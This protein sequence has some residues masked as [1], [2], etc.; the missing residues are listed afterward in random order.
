MRT[1]STCLVALTFMLCA[2]ARAED[3]QELPSYVLLQ[4]SFVTA[5]KAAADAVFYAYDNKLAA[6][7]LKDLGARWP[8]EFNFPQG[9]LFVI[10]VSSYTKESFASMSG[11]KSS[12][13]F[14]VNLQTDKETEQPTPAAEGKKNVRLLLI[15][16]PPIQG[17][18]AWA[19]K[20]A[21][22]KL[23]A[24]DGAELKK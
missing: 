21:D 12:K 18:K 24:V 1:C 3:P 17:I 15:G 11:V 19:I 10:V 4:D 2:S 13:T 8:K 9:S 20:T 23:H 22:A 14:I 7:K 6:A 5:D 16:C